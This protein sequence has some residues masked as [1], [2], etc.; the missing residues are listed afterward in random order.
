MNI[1][2]TSA[3]RI[4]DRSNKLYSRVA[5]IYAAWVRLGSLGAFPNL[6]REGATALA[7]S[8]G[9]TVLDMCCGTGEL[10]PFLQKAV[11]PG[12]RIVGCDL[13]PV[14]L[15][16]AQARATSAGWG[17][18]DLVCADALTFQPDRPIDAAIFSICL[19]A[20][21]WRVEVLDHVIGLLP[22]GGRVVIIDSLTIPGR[23]LANLYN[24]AKGRIIGADPDCGL[25]NA[26][27]DRLSDLRERHAAGGVYSLIEGRTFQRV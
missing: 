7:L 10:L 3:V 2:E 12:G 1:A 6:Y 15:A 11:G 13:S 4:R 26:A 16:Q 23:G 27:A 22:S 20:I 17:N 14:M 9:Q 19:S 18:V 5:A 24:R 8:P 25:R 21:P